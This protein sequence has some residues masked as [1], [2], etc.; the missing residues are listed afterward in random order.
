MLHWLQSLLPHVPRYGYVLVSI[1]VFLNNLGFPLPGETILLGAGFILAK[2][3]GSLWQP[4][5]AGTMACFL[6]GACAFW[7]GRRLGHSSLEKIHWL[8]LTPERRKWPERF[9][10]NHGARAVFIARFIPL[11][12]PVA[13]NLLAGMSKISW[14]TYLFYDFVGSAAYTAAYILIGY[15]FG[16]RWKLLEAWLGPTALYLI[17]A[18]MAGVVLGAMLRHSLSR[19]WARL[20]PKAR[21]GSQ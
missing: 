17:L 12:P 9:F 18:G 21:K 1:V 8:R 6:G 3:A 10:K 2:V 15:F 13:A 14:R 20:L 7:M 16:K 5:V 4:V 11:F 19:L